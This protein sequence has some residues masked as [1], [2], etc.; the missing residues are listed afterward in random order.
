MTSKILFDLQSKVRSLLG[1]V[2]TL[3]AG[4]GG[5]GVTDHGALTGLGDDDHT[6]Y[7][8]DARGDARYSLTTHSHSNA[9]TTVAGFMSATDKTKLD[10][11]SASAVVYFKATNSSTTSLTANT[12][13]KLTINSEVYDSDGCYDPTTNYRFTPT[14]AGYYFINGRAFNST[15]S[16]AYFIAYLYFNGSKVSAGTLNPG[17]TTVGSIST[18]QT[19]LYFNGSTDYVELWAQASANSTVGIDTS[20]VVF[21]GFLVR[22]V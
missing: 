19:I 13:K 16:L 12:A 8:T 3:E 5:G 1:R 2:S 9:S 4:G 18:V 11:L 7:H 21:E 14:T 6:Q 22:G 15:N 17:T 10:A 20:A